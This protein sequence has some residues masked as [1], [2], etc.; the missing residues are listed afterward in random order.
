MEQ[1]QTNIPKLLAEKYPYWGER[2]PEILQIDEDMNIIKIWK[3]KKEIIEFYHKKIQGL[4]LALRKRC[5]FIGFFW[6][7]KVLYEK[8]GIRP[9]ITEKRNS[10][11]Y[12]YDPPEYICENYNDYKISDFYSEEHKS[13]FRFIGRFNNSVIVGEHLDLSVTNIRRVAKG[14]IPLHKG[15]FFSFIPIYNI[16]KLSSDILELIEKR[17]RFGISEEEINRF[18]SLIVDFKKEFEKYK[19]DKNNIISDLDRKVAKMINIDS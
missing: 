3:N 12:A 10:P 16:H 19:Y 13:K 15:Y 8:E 5:R 17:D 2:F 1:D 4:D 18:N 7:I 11:I 14:E 9:I 6:I